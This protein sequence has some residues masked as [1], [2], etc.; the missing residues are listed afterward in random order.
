LQDAT[1]LQQL[2]LSP[3][4]LQDLA[5]KHP[6]VFSGGRG[7]AQ[8]VLDVA[9][10][11]GIEGEDVEGFLDAVAKDNPD[12]MQVFTSQGIGNDGAHPLSHAAALF[13]LVH[14][15]MP[16][17][18]AFVKEHSPGLVGA[19]ADARRMADIGYEGSDRSPESVAGLLANNHDPAY[20][21]EIINNLR[22]N[23]TLD[24]FVQAMGTNLHYNGWPEAARSAIQNAAGAGVIT[25]TQAQSYL[26]RVG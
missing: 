9:N 23:N 24:H 14:Q 11:N 21:A 15:S 13:N 12:Y 4:Q 6:E 18:S 20:Q 25:Q 19:D 2:N 17:A 3:K 5:E 8:S 16:T 26:T 7:G 22:K 10:A 1:L